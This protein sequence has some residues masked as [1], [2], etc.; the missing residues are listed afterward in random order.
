MRES[1][2]EVQKQALNI[3]ALLKGFR[4]AVHQNLGERAQEDNSI[5]GRQGCEDQR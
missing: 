5:R 1:S 2:D 4:A 3:N